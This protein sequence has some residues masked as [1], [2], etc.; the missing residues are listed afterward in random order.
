VISGTS[1]TETT[2]T[3]RRLTVAVPGV[4]EFQERYE[5]A[6]PALPLE[7]VTALVDRRAPWSEMLDLIAKAL[8]TGS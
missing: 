5:Q 8:R 2:Y 6:V 7:Q 3:V 4:R 1:E